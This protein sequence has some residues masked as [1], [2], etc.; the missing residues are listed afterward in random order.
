MRNL[1]G[2]TAGVPGLK[3]WAGAQARLDGFHKLGMDAEDLA[4]ILTLVVE[5][6]DGRF[7]PVAVVGT[8]TVYL[9]RML[10]DAGIYVTNVK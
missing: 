5:R 7:V 3:T 9:A 10:A 1:V 4:K 2:E 6:P 8:S